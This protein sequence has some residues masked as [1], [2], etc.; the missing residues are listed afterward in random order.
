MP[1]IKNVIS[2]LSELDDETDIVLMWWAKDLFEQNN[3]LISNYIWQEVTELI[4]TEPQV[5][6]IEVIYSEIEGLI[7]ESL[8]N[9]LG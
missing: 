2:R 6:S 8:S 3:N 1:K 5:L 9:V 4:D 7:K